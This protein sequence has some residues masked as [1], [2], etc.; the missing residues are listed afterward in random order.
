MTSDSSTNSKVRIRRIPNGILNWLQEACGAPQLYLIALVLRLSF[1]IASQPWNSDAYFAAHFKSNV[2]E[3]EYH[4][5]ALNLIETGTFNAGGEQ[6]MSAYPDPDARRPPLFPLFLAAVYL[7]FGVHPWMAMLFQAMLCA[8]IPVLVYR[9][10]RLFLDRSQSA[11]AGLLCAVEPHLI[12]MSSFFLTDML[13]T[14]CVVAGIYGFLLFI[15]S[16][17]SKPLLTSGVLIGASALFKPASVLL[18]PVL[19]VILIWRSIKGRVAVMSGPLFVACFL[20]TISPWLLRNQKVYGH[21]QLSSVPGMNLYLYNAALTEAKIRQV[22]Q[23]VVSEAFKDEARRQ[24]DAQYKADPSLAND[25]NNPFC[26]SS[27][28]RDLGVQYLGKHLGDYVGLHFAGSWQMFVHMG[29]QRIAEVVHITRP[30]TEDEKSLLLQSADDVSAHIDQKPLGEKLLMFWLMGSALMYYLLTAM[31][32]LS[33][34]EFIR[35]G[36]YWWVIGLVILYF[37]GVVGPVGQYRY[38][39]PIIPFYCLFAGVGAIRILRWL[40]QKWA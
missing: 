24:I 17:G 11:M 16:G 37:I 7:I 12:I 18:V 36:W 26:V 3:T 39:L 5:L 32:V 35:K 9:I 13:F 34:R 28:Y 1:L 4:Q 25:P 20:L 14:L 8:L 21:Y 10:G 33:W 2:D 27:M 38:K 30:K 22:E 23:S 19:A 6:G 40:Q 29:S 31:G 15:H